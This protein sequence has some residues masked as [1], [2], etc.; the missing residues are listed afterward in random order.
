M[1]G[2]AEQNMIETIAVRTMAKAY[3]STHN[4]GHYGLAF[5]FYTHFTSPIR[6]YPDLMVHRLLEFYIMGGE[7]VDAAPFE[8]RCEHSSEMEKKAA[9]AERA[10]VKYKQAEFMVDKIGQHFFGT[11]SGVS[12]WGIYVSLDE[13]YCEGLV[14]MRSML[15]DFY[16]LDEENYQVIGLRTGRVYK[17]GQRVEIVVQEIDLNKKQLTFCFP[18]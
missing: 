3:Y 16:E 17:L 9:D 2:K 7:S 10:S 18:S 4:I 8:S 14:P 13:N 5:P 6:R 1:E 11:V 15:D 12:K